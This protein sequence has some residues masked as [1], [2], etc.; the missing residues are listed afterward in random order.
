MKSFY[1][2]TFI[3]TFRLDNLYFREHAKLN[4]MQTVGKTQEIDF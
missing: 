1:V 4:M 3:K 2:F